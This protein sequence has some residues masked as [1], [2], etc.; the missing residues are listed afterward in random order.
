MKTHKT[1]I[2]EISEELDLFWKAQ[3][4]KGLILGSVALIRR[5]TTKLKDNGLYPPE[6]KGE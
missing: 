1:L 2:N 3:E 5:I 4:G 6:Q